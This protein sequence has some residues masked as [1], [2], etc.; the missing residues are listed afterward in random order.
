MVKFTDISEIFAGKEKRTVHIH[1][2][3]H[4]KRSSG[5]V[6]FLLIR[7][8]TGI[9]QTT[10]KKDDV[11]EEAYQQ[12]DR[13]P[14]ESTVEIEGTVKEDERAPGGCE[15]SIHDIRILHE[16]KE[17][18]PIAK[19]Y[20]GPEFLMDHRH[21]WLRNE[22][23]QAM[24]KIRSKIL[25]SS[26]EW[27]LSHGYIEFQSPVIITA[28]VEGGSTLFE[29]KYFNRK[30]YLTQSWQLHAEAAIASVGKIFTIAPSFRAEKSRTR[31][32]LTEYW[33]IEA[34]EPWCDLKKT[35]KVQ[36]E[37]VTHVLHELAKDLPREMETFGRDPKDLLKIKPS[38]PRITYDQAAEMLRKEGVSVA[39]GEDL[40]W[41]QQ[42]VL[43]FKFQ[44]PFFITHFP[45]SAKAFY[46]KPD[47]ERSDVTLSDDL[48]AP[49]GYGELIGGGQRIHD[50]DELLERIKEEELDAKN[51]RWYIELR[52]F[53]PV[54]HAGFGLGLERLIMWV[55][56]LDHIRDAIPFP[57]TLTRI[58]P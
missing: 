49:E 19:K 41:E 21:L 54:P 36:E 24:L 56:K 13:L 23:M 47:P 37:L 43:S 28:A 10:L 44:T 27:F 9:I 35:M 8:G 22:K 32:H 26:R 57:R 55:C 39:W 51:Y 38:F 5:G 29:L 2:W 3:L 6:Q 33:H 46:H 50:L 25:E 53:G 16:V 11:P 12:I 15:L 1:G 48:Q 34:E 7:D 30:A 18:F 52:K 40:T 58:Y 14:V 20:H 31:R 17:E 4:H 42:K 45:K